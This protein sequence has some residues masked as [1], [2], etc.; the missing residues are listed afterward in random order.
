ME[1]DN[2]QAINEIVTG[3]EKKEEEQQPAAAQPAEEIKEKVDTENNGDGQP[4]D[5]GGSP[6]GEP[7]A[8]QPAAAPVNEPAAKDRLDALLEEL[9]VKDVEG[10]KA[11][12]ANVDKVEKTT[13]EKA[14]DEAVFKKNFELFAVREKL[15]DTA[16][17]ITHANVTA[18]ANYDLVFKNYLED[19]KAENEAVIKENENA[20]E[21]D[22]IQLA[23]ADFETEFKL[24]SDS[25]KAKERGEKKLAS[26][27]EAL[28][29][30]VK[31]KYDA[32]LQ[33]FKEQEE[34]RVNLPK[35]VKATEGIITGLIKDE[36]EW[37]KGKD[38]ET[39]FSVA[40]KVPE[41]KRKEIADYVA[42][43]LDNPQTFMLYQQGKTDDIAELAE[44][45]V[46]AKVSKIF[47]Q[48]AAIEIAKKHES[49]GIKKGSN[50]S[51]NSFAMNN[52]D[53]ADKQ[54]TLTEEQK[55]LDSFKK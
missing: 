54:Q 29:S 22:L 34:M 21:E 45:L 52:S 46:E 28:R 5:Q 55:V 14:H 10:L 35:F 43:K 9:G 6:S 44:A 38:G 27:A 20:S 36:I 25:A 4:A 49:I 2:I 15:M 42:K 11:L 1:N 32:A 37:Y 23:K 17:F 47:R 33:Q 50:G 12:K 39:E 16:D 26:E 7:A 3:A 19:W 31:S 8:A 18:Q 53:A 30:P 48:E 24:N 13:E 40:I 41:D 51:V